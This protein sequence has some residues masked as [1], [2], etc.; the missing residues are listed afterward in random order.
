MVSTQLEVCPISGVSKPVGTVT[1]RYNPDNVEVIP[2]L[3][4]V[5]RD[6]GWL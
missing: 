2:A 3:T 4:A 6:K 5:F 1:L